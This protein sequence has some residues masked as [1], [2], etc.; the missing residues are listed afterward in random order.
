M[1][2]FTISEDHEVLTCAVNDVEPVAKDGHDVLVHV[3]FSGVNFKDALVAAPQSRVRRVASLV[4]GVDAA[5]TVVESSHGDLPVGAR[6]AVHGGNI[7]VGRDGGFAE[8]IY[9]PARYLSVLPATIST[10]DAMIIGTAGLTAMQSVLALEDRGLQMNDE[11][12]VT[13][14]TGGVGSMSVAFLAIRG[15]RPVASTGSAGES[16]WL[17]ARGADRVISRSDV[18]DQLGRVLGSELWLRYGAAVAACGLVASADLVTTVYPFITRN[19]ALLG[20]DCVEATGATRSRVWSAL[21][22]TIT[23]LDI[24]P[25]VDRVVDLDEIHGALDDIRHGKTRGRILVS[26]TPG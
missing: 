8:F 14:A 22:D 24:E 3:D 1:R 17:T 21:G 16:E 9:A 23:A 7:G 2:A 20:I 15:Y 10:R 25:L 26:P 4:G 6:V 12:L 5:G 13:G 18:T 11:I 19:V